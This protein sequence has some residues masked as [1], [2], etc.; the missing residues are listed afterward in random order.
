MRTTFTVDPDLSARL[1]RVRRER[2]VSM[3]R[4]VN[5]LIRAG[6]DAKPKKRRRYRMKHAFDA[7]LLVRNLD[8]AM[9]VLEQLE[10]PGHR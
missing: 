9:D 7:R 2:G 4:V 1:E 3:A 6:L 5:E 10:G 8:D